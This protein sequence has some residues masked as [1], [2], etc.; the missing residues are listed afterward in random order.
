MDAGAIMQ[1]QAL[2]QRAGVYAGQ[3]ATRLERLHNLVIPVEGELEEAS[4]LGFTPGRPRGVPPS[5]EHPAYALLHIGTTREQER[6]AYAY[7]VA[8]LILDGRGCSVPLP[9]PTTLGLLALPD[10]DRTSWIEALT[11][12]IPPDLNWTAAPLDDIARLLQLPLPMLE[13]YAMVW[14]AP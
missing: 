1:L 8:W 5:R 3:G 14:Q 13:F 4:V 9:P 7:L 12:L 11:L 2:A 6:L 10:R